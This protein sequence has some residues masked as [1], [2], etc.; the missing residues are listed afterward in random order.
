[1]NSP[2]VFKQ[3]CFNPNR[4]KTAVSNREHV[5]YIATRT[6]VVKNEG[7]GHGLFGKAFGMEQCGDISDLDKFKRQVRDIS[8]Q[9]TIVYRTV[10]SLTEADAIEKGYHRREAWE[11]LFQNNLGTIAEKM[12]IPINRL[13][14]CAAVHMDK[15]HPHVH[16]LYWEREQGIRKAW[17]PPAQ[18]DSIRR[19]LNKYVFAEEFT[20]A[21]ADKNA[22]RDGVDQH[23]GEALAEAFSPL[24]DMDS[25]EYNRLLLELQATDPDL[26]PG[27]LL[28]NKIPADRYAAIMA[29]I[30]RLRADLPKTGRLSYK[31]MPPEIKERIDS[32]IMAIL[33]A[34]TDCKREFDRYLHTAMDIAKMNT[35]NADII[36]EAGKKA[37]AELMN[38][39]GNKILQTA[40]G[41]SELEH[42]FSQEQRREYYRQQAAEKL[43]SEVFFILSSTTRHQQAN[44]ASG[45]AGELSKQAKKELAMKMQDHTTDWER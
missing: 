34:N 43:V 10:I 15:G 25:E 45:R 26:C 32:I 11:A 39:I 16:F 44:I 27:G 19:G 5:R 18:S 24:A 33:A 40:K 12:R 13:E 17:I 31:L 41:L 2:L 37:F 8:L 35:S 21:Y 23:S 20:Q 7:M 4:P 6:G 9:K 42:Q 3:R 36:D 38:K 1:M 29:D 28:Y 14:W 30:I 22:A